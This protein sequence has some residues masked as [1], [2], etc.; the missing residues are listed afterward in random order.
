[1]EIFKPI[2]P[3]A[4]AGSLAEQDSPLSAPGVNKGVWR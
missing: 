2:T 4:V 1:M 3:T